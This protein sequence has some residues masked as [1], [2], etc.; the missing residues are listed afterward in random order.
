MGK[1]KEF[2]QPMGIDNFRINHDLIVESDNLFKKLAIRLTDKFSLALSPNSKK[3]VIASARKLCKQ[4]DNLLATSHDISTY[5]KV[6]EL[7]STACDV[8]VDIKDET[9]LYSICT[10]DLTIASTH[11]KQRMREQA[12][13]F[14]SSADDLMKRKR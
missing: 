12:E 6:V 4:A 1:D 13:L 2:I 11:L 5:Q 9:E 8:L 3:A 7:L 14:T 10:D